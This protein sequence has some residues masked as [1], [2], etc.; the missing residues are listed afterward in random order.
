LVVA[1]ILGSVIPFTV[2]VVFPINA[3]LL[4]PTLDGSSQLSAE[5]LRRWARLHA[6]R[7]VLSVVA[8]PLFTLLGVRS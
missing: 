4:D 7:T 8:F 2:F 5:L 6:V 3:Q 1:L